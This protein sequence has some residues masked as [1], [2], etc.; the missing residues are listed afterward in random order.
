M[1]R[2]GVR[3][4]RQYGSQSVAQQSSKA[5]KQESGKVIRRQETRDSKQQPTDGPPF[6]RPAQQT[7][8]IRGRPALRAMANGRQQKSTEN[9]R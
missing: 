8:R 4:T 1:K 2:S 9:A 5:G 3:A 7:A 6:R